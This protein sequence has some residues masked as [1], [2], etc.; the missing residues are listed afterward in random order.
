MDAVFDSDKDRLTFEYEPTEV[1][2][3]TI[4]ATSNGE[5]IGASP[6][7]VNPKL[8]NNPEINNSIYF[9]VTVSP[10]TP[11]KVRAFGAGLKSGIVNHPSVFSVETNGQA[12]GLGIIHL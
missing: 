12:D 3:Y 2:E 6:Y 5:P 9:Q 1:G 11:S 8:L 10:A 4:E 7:K